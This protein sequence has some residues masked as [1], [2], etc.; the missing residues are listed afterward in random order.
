MIPRLTDLIISHH[1]L[2]RNRQFRK[3]VFAN[4]PQ[5]DVKNKLAVLI[6]EDFLIRTFLTKDSIQLKLGAKHGLIVTS[7]VI[8]CYWFG[9]IHGLLIQNDGLPSVARYDHGLW[10]EPA[11]LN[12][13]WNDGEDEWGECKDQPDVYYDR[14]EG[15]IEKRFKSPIAN[16]T[17]DFVLANCKRNGI[18]LLYDE[19]DTPPPFLAPYF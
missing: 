11:L 13:F 12:L 14:V 4:F 16:L 19:D 3:S 18:S 1:Q 7:S 17:I 10:T 8:S 5:S 15:M 9:K 6:I 2:R